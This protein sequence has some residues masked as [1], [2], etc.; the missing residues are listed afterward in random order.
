MKFLVTQ[1]NQVTQVQQSDLKET[2]LENVFFY[3]LSFYWLCCWFPAEDNLKKCEDCPLNPKVIPGAVQVSVNPKTC[4]K[5]K[6]NNYNKDL[7]P[8]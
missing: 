3:L 6:K 2:I 1:P 5:N 4:S 8:I 7:S